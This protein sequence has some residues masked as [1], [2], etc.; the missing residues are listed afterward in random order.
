MLFRPL[1]A[2]KILG[3]RVPMTP[4]VIPSKRH[5]LAHNIGEMVGEHL[6]TSKEIGDA[7]EKREFKEHLHVVIKNRAETIFSSDLGPLPTLIPLRFVGYY[8]TGVQ[9]VQLHL[10]NII[11]GFIATKDVTGR[12]ESLVSERLNTFLERELETVLDEKTLK[13]GCEILE[14][15]IGRM[16]RS[17]SF[18]QWLDDYVYR[19]VNGVLRQGQSCEDILPGSLKQLLLKTIEQQTPALLEK[20]AEI[21]KEPD[22]QDKIVSGVKEGVENFIES[23]GPMSSMVHNFISP[24]LIDEKVREYLKEKEDDIVLWLQNPEVQ[25]RVTK[26]I[27]ERASKYLQTPIGVLIPDEYKGK[28]N[29]FCNGMTQQIL[30]ILQ[31]E[32][33]AKG[34]VKILSDTM[35]VHI[36]KGYTIKEILLELVGNDTVEACSRRINMEVLQLLKSQKAVNTINVMV[37]TMI[38]SLLSRR[39]GR[40]NRILPEGMRESMYGSLQ[41]IT[42]AM[43][44]SEIP[45]VVDSLNLR[46]IVA[47]KI[48]SLDLLRLEGLL[49]S[50]MEEQFKYINLFGALL[51]FIIGLINLI[52]LQL[53]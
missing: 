17:S 12:I 44:A 43:L 28:V 23:L 19:K 14:R 47:D 20:F 33:S 31:D 39:I 36:K 16:L 5:E 45:G 35:D 21:L 26:S 32:T 11:H 34:L 49:L 2:W 27:K 8:E 1:R 41:T 51:G 4:G 40:L 42:S 29:V 25:V 7:L 52:F 13:S 3:I 6:L 18:E 9:M 53:S 46:Q 22:I 38:A 30:S 24:D 48:D 50:I 10:Q 15:N 37:E